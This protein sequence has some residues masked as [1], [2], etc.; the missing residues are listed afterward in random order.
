MRRIVEWRI[1]LA[2]VMGASVIAPVALGQ[3]LAPPPRSIA[4][5]TAVLDSEK[6]DPAK[7]AR[8]LAQA[9]APVPSG[10]SPGTVA[11]F[12]RDRSVAASQLGRIDQWIADATEALR[13]ADQVNDANI[14]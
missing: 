3:T 12:Y 7:L 2:L 11:E 1:A 9:D 10:A 5:I 6:P 14:A 13:F 4:D 8:Y